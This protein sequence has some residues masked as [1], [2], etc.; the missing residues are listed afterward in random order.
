LSYAPWLPWLARKSVIDV[1]AET[2]GSFDVAAVPESKL[3]F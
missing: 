1:L 3:K 2:I